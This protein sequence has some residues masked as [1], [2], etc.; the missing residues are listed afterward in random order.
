MEINGKTV[1]ILYESAPHQVEVS[2]E[3]PYFKS[4]IEHISY[5]HEPKM[6]YKTIESLNRNEPNFYEQYAMLCEINF[7]TND[8]TLKYTVSLRL[9]QTTL[10]RFYHDAGKNVKKS[11][12]L[13]NK[14]EIK[15]K[16]AER[17]LGLAVNGTQY[18][19]KKYY[20]YATIA[21]PSFPIYNRFCCD[22]TIDG[23]VYSSNWITPNSVGHI[24]NSY[25]SI[26]ICFF[27]LICNAIVSNDL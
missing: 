22:F 8:P 25:Q 7:E 9:N 16:I 27:V 12:N 5:L 18:E 15:F 6:S 20:F 1:S 19:R 26:L 21:D 23:N 24:S 10:G 2:C 11:S 4:G 14:Q 13:A 17:I 3:L